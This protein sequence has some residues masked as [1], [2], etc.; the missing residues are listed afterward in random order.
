MSWGAPMR[1]A[2]FVEAHARASGE[3]RRGDGVF[4]VW[5][6]VGDGPAKDVLEQGVGFGDDVLAGVGRAMV[7]RADER[8]DQ[9]SQGMIVARGERSGEVAGVA[10]VEWW[11]ML[12]GWMVLTGTSGVA[13]G[14]GGVDLST[15]PPRRYLAFMTPLSIP[16]IRGVRRAVGVVGRHGCCG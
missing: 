5:A 11:A 16:A 6:G 2:R 3:R 7:G 8:L 9:T 15:A 1:A 13:V 12:A 14:A 4:P 10:V